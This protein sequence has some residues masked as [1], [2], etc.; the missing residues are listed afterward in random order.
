MADTKNITDN[1]L[2]MYGRNDWVMRFN[3]R[4]FMKLTGLMDLPRDAAILDCG[5]GM[6][7]LIYMMNQEGFTTVSGLDAAPEMVD[8]ARKLTGANIA[9]ADVVDIEKSYEKS[10][11]DAV[12]ISDIVHHIPDKDQ[13]DKMLA[14]C[15]AVL[16]P[17]G[18]LAIREPFPNLAVNS[19]IFMSGIKTLHIG[20]MKSRL[21]S[22]VEEADLVDYFFKNW[23]PDYKEKLGGFGFKIIKDFNWL[24]HRITVAGKKETAP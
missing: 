5:C 10:S 7:H 14:G 9:L 6:G 12:I 24:V 20:F 17:G 16:K 13:W 21:Q 23:V 8:A 3:F 15:Y 1:L 19:L 18:L 22:F 4:M 11:L 2:E